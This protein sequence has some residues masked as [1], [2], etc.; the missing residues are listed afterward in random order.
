MRLI[1]SSETRLASVLYRKSG[2]LPLCLVLLL[3]ITC[4][5]NYFLFSVLF[6]SHVLGVVQFSTAIFILWLHD[7]SEAGIF[8]NVLLCGLRLLIAFGLG[9][10][11]SSKVWLCE[12]CLAKRKHFV[13][14]HKCHTH[15][16]THTFSMAK[17]TPLAHSFP[18][19]FVLHNKSLTIVLP[20]GAF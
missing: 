14:F 19:V 12:H 18:Q 20:T 3:I 2:S 17:F 7:V 15:P 4:S 11:Q 9:A 6:F 1:T 16:H 8:A 10:V 5:L 13:K